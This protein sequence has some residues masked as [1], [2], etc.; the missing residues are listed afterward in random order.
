MKRLKIN[1]VAIQQKI[2]GYVR[3]NNWMELLLLVRLLRESRK[4]EEKTVNCF[5]WRRP[6]SG[7][8]F[9]TDEN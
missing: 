6:I 3:C 9:C 8:I 4:E 7:V 1:L 2:N 5:W